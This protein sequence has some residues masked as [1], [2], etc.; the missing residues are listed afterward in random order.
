MP[1]Q[2]VGKAWT[3]RGPQTAL[4]QALVERAGAPQLIAQP[5]RQLLERPLDEVRA[6]LRIPQ[7]VKYRECHRIWQA[8]GVNPHNLLASRKPAEPELLAA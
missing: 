3:R 8:E 4:S 1:R 7:P 2:V 5:I 6:A